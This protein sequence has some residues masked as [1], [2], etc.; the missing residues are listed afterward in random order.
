MP[1]LPVLKQAWDSQSVGWDVLVREEL[2]E[3][4][5]R[6]RLGLR[7]AL[8]MPVNSGAEMLGVLT[9]GTRD[10]E[11]PDE[12]PLAALRSITNLI[13]QVMERH[14]AEH[15]AERMKNEFFAL[16]SHELDA[17]DLDHRLS[18]D[19]PRAGRGP[20]RT[21]DQRQLPEVI[22]RNARRLHRLVSDLLF[23]AQIEAGRMP[24]N[25]KSIGTGGD[26]DRGRRRGAT[27]GRQEGRR[28]S[29]DA[30]P[31]QTTGD[32]ERLGQLIDNLISNAIKFTPEGGGVSVRLRTAG[33][34]R[35]SRSPTPE[36]GSPRRTREALRALLSD[37]RR[38]EAGDPG[39]R[40][41]ALDCKAI[42]ESPRRRDLGESSQGQGQPSGSSCRSTTGQRAGT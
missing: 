2:S 41:R 18:G 1:D 34:T 13:G 12:A 5:R 8:A 20:A 37:Q 26:R 9:F 14:D 22:D 7:A 28:L 11:A 27:A 39:A 24:P 36:W 40:P 30:Q 35:C 23:I 17:A 6:R 25:R 42:A 10:G 29:L 32:G 19:R 15:E 3:R 4:Q 21:D 38:D 33:R 31:V 16:V